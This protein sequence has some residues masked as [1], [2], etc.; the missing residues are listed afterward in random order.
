ML[1][2]DG[3]F[4]HFHIAVHE[5]AVIKILYSSSACMIIH[6]NITTAE[7]MACL[8]VHDNAGRND[9]AELQEE[10]KK[11]FS[12]SFLVEVANKYIHK[13]GLNE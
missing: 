3:Y 9:L 4:I 12:G 7:R 5:D 13:S 11:M 10:L 1:P 6:F 2:G 8:V